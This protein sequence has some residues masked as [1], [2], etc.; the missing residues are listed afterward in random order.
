MFT[1]PATRAGRRA[2]GALPDSGKAP[3][4]DETPGPAQAGWA[5][6]QSHSGKA[7]TMPIA[8][9]TRRQRQTGRAR[10]SAARGTAARRTTRTASRTVS[11]GRARA[12]QSRVAGRAS[13]R[14][15][16]TARRGVRRPATGGPTMEQLYREARRRNIRGRSTMTKAQLSRA[17]GR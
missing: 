12:G 3:A 7:G 15:M 9:S 1:G 14:T 6:L 8:S 4:A 2:S 10:T 13:T 16:S 11:T 17:L 5:A